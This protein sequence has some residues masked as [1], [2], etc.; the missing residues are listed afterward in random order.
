MDLAA[1][2]AYILYEQTIQ[3]QQSM[4]QSEIT[5]RKKVSVM[6]YSNP[7]ILDPEQDPKNR[8]ATAGGGSTS[9]SGSLGPTGPPGRPGPMGPIGPTGFMGPIG[10]NGLPGPTGPRGPTG[11]ACQCK[12]ALQTAF[13]RTMLQ[14]EITQ[15]VSNMTASLPRDGSSSSTSSVSVVGPTGPAGKQGLQGWMGPTGPQ[16]PPGPPGSA[17]TVTTNTTV[18]ANSVGSYYS[19]T[20]QPIAMGKYGVPPTALTFTTTTAESNLSLHPT[21]KSQIRIQHSGH[22]EVSYTLSLTRPPKT[23][24]DYVYIWLRVNNGTGIPG[25]T[26][27]VFVPATVNAD[28]ELT[29]SNSY[30]LRLVEGEIIELVAVSADPYCS[31][32]VIQG[33]VFGPGPIPAVRVCVKQLSGATI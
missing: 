30:V 29:I 13:D 4:E 6:K 1:C 11:P 7:Y 20:S 22:Y 24:G 15:I 31:T 10:R 9:T 8:S 27:R 5:L 19:N 25:T 23:K 33:P 21:N 14:H 26:S 28:Q 32:K 2:L 16:G 17:S 3:T 12:Y 18:S